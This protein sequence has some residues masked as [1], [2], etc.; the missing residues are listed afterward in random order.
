[1]PPIEESRDKHD[2]V[3]RNQDGEGHLTV[4]FTFCSQHKTDIMQPSASA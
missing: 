1:M 3:E 2:K 4:S